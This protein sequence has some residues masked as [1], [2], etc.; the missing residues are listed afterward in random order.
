MTNDELC[1]VY[2]DAFAAYMKKRKEKVPAL[3]G[4]SEPRSTRTNRIG[5]AA[6]LGRASKLRGQQVG[7]ELVRLRLGEIRCGPGLD[8]VPGSG[9]CA[10]RVGALAPGN[11]P[12]LRGFGF[13]LGCSTHPPP[14]GFGFALKVS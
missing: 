7:S 3:A 1:R 5:Y 8:P 4:C 12:T 11:P 9:V 2:V 6:F 14:P 10:G 13:P